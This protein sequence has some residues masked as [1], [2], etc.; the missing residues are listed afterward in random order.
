MGT[1]F[2]PARLGGLDVRNRILRSATAERR[3]DVNGYP[4]EALAAFYEDL[5]RGGVGTIITGMMTVLKDDTGYPGRLALYEDAQIAPIR[6]ITG[7]VHAAGAKIVAQ[8]VQ[9]GANDSFRDGGIICGPSAVEHPVYHVVPKE[10]TKN[11][12]RL[13]V[14][15]F[16]AAARR[17]KEAGFDAVE[18]HGAHGY[19]LN[20]WLAPF[21]NRRTDEYGGSLEN[22]MRLILEIYDA[23]RAAAGPG[24][25]VWIKLNAEDFT[26]GGS[27]FEDC[28]S[29]CRALDKRGIDLIEMS[30][31]NPARRR[32]GT[33]APEGYFSAYAAKAAEELKADVV[34]V[35][36]YRSTALMEKLLRETN[37]R[38]F[39]LS[40]PLLCEPDL[41]NKWAA[42]PA[43]KPRCIS[44]NQCFKHKPGGTAC[45]FNIPAS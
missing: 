27:T 4:T 21:F 35:G 44:C 16:G 36:G 41:V 34:S 17:A 13:L 7:R 37:I 11:D 23:I 2:E 8:L 28:L 32:I 22:R 29:V 5:A 31:G 14:A 10:M 12:I 3:A 20:A 33:E 38:G 18:L 40:R 26:D 15:A 25:P 30:G 39:A 6:A 45:I 24:Y 1:L 19:L 9:T 43:Y 42:D